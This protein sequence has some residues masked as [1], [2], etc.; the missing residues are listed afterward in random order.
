MAET[1]EDIS[2]NVPVTY[3][4]YAAHATNLKGK[5]KTQLSSQAPCYVA[6]QEAQSHR[7][8]HHAPAESR[9]STIISP[10]V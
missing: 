2:L 7:A 9:P 8:S 1:A 5:S 10:P 4:E 6:Q 3:M